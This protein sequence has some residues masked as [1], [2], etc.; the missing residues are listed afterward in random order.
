MLLVRHVGAAAQSWADSG[1]DDGELYRGA[2]L[3]S[4]AAW[5]T[6]H[7]GALGSIESDFVASSEALAA[8]ESAE[9]AARA[10][11]QHR[12]HRRL[13]RLTV[14]ACCAAVLALTAGSIA[15]VQS[16]RGADDRRADAREAEADA[17]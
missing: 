16:V 17:R 14:A 5:A 10:A 7:P 6:A 12:Q 4:V 11:E 3:E 13:R 1:R 9:R 2:R 8:Q 15:I